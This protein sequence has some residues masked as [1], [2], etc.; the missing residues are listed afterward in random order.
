MGSQIES[1]PNWPEFSTEGAELDQYNLD[2]KRSIIDQYGEGNLKSSWLKVCEKL[3]EVTADISRDGTKL[4]PD[5]P[6]SE[7]MS[8]ST[9]RRAEITSRGCCVVRGVIPEEEAS[10]WFAELKTFIKEN[11][12]SSSV[13]TWPHGHPFLRLYYTPTQMRARSHPNQLA[14]Q[15]ILNSLWHDSTNET[16]SE[17]LTYC[18]AFKIRVPGIPFLGLPPHIDAG[19]LCRWADPTYRKVYDAV[20]SGR[21]SELDLYNLG[22]RKGANQAMFNAGAQSSVLRTFQGWTAI[23][24]LKHDEGGMLIYPNVETAVAY[25]LLRPFLKEPTDGD[26][27]DASKW[28]LDTESGWFPG[29]FRDKSQMASISSHPHL[30]LRDCMVHLPSLRPGDTVWW[31]SDMLH[32]V[33]V[34]HKGNEDTAVIYIA[35]TPTTAINQKYIAKQLQDFRE[36]HIPHDFR[37]GFDADERKLKGF[38]GEDSIL[39]DGRKAFGMTS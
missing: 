31:H 17:P 34:D 36:G 25:V 5:L 20:F 37:P 21:P 39:P 1:W 32:A 23:T 38:I 15:R 6:F 12:G 33:E 9:E 30:R 18:D 8:L 4:I 28:T 2:L 22:T 19:S 3:A 11:E 24:P 16:S 29:T 14:I 26:V 10:K 7:I 13:S 35:A 27:M